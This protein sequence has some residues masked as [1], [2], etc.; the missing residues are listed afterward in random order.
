V[1]GTKPAVNRASTPSLAAKLSAV[2][3]PH[4]NAA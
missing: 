1:E 2:C 3:A 4:Q